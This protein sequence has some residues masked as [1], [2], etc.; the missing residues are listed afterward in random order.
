MK[1]GGWPP[2]GRQNLYFLSLAKIK[3][4]AYIAITCTLL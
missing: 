4:T 1:E 3:E 2:I